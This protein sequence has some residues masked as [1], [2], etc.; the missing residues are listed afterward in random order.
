[1]KQFLRL[2]VLSALF[3]SMAQTVKSQAVTIPVVFHVLYGSTPQNLHDSILQDQLDVMN[4]DLNANNADLWKV[5]SV[6]QPI[7]GNMQINFV[8]ANIDPSGNPTTGIERRQHVGS[9][10]ANDMM[11]HFNSGGL[12]AWPDTSYLNVWVCNLSGPLGYT[13]LPGGPAATDGIVLHYAAVG[14]YAPAQQAPFNAGRIGTHEFGHWLGL[15]H[16]G[17]DNACA[18]IDSCADTPGFTSMVVGSYAVGTILTDACQPNAPGIMW[19]NFMMYTDDTSMVFF[20]QDQITRMT[21]YLNNMRQ[22]F[23]TPDGIVTGVRPI[24]TQ[25]QL[26]VFP[27]PSSSGTFTLTRVD[28]SARAEVQLYDVNGQHVDQTIEFPAGNTTLQIDLSAFA[29]GVYSVVVR[30]EFDL[31][32]KAIVIAR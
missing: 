24:E 32:T 13:Q 12:D 2:A 27:S 9:W 29:D 25:S 5:P 15:A 6:W 11:K 19:M 14:R 10:Q 20:T 26:S 31:Q 28:G 1:M 17:P 21:W 23:F 4:E 7:I 30:S 8:L 22:G 3:G 18:D 16:I